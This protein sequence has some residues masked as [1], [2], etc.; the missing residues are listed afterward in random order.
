M[1]AQTVFNSGTI[2]EGAAR[3]ISTVSPQNDKVAIGPVLAEDI[4]SLFVWFHDSQARQSA[5]PSRPVD[6]IGFKE[7]LDQ[8]VSLTTQILFVVRSLAPARAVGFVLFK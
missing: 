1:S 8:N 3:V 2:H 7:W 4:A 5:L 6:S